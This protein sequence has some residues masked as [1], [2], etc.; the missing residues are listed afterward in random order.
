M[1]VEL[2][3]SDLI[4]LADLGIVRAGCTEHLHEV[5]AILNIPRALHSLAIVRAD[6]SAPAFTASNDARAE[7]PSTNA[8]GNVDE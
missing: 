1:A 7:P 5:P 6:M 4:D 8:K 2:A 3:R